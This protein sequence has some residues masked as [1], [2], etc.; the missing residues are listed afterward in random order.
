MSVRQD[1]SGRRWVQAE[2]EVPGTPEQVWQAIATGPG[3]SSWF[4][5]TE[6]QEDGTVVA[7]FGPGMD[8]VATETAWDPPRRFAAEGEL[9]PGA[10]KMAT[11]WTVEAHSG[12]TCIV[13][14]V[15]SV[16]TERDDWD[17]QLESIEGGWPD[18]FENL[19]LYL[20]HFN[21]QPCAPF[22]LMGMSGSPASEVWDV[23]TGS[24]GLVAAQV[25]EHRQSPEGAPPLSGV[26]ERIG[27]PGHPW[28]L[29]LRLDGPAPGIAHMFAMGMG[30]MTLLVL[31]FYLFGEQASAVAAEQEPRWQAWLG[32]QFPA[33]AAPAEVTG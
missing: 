11:E 24:L 17:G 22:Q 12:S 10:P 16:F 33:P 4:V 15:H 2:V 3:V 25:G 7:H 28:A 18:Y 23:A 5:P 14:V 19:R 29:L 1:P 13:R 21:G 30:G 31:R 9:G 32:E 6:K 27:T 26:V 20:I 8:A